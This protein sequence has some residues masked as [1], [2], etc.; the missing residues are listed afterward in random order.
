MNTDINLPKTWQEMAARINYSWLWVNTR[1][2]DIRLMCLEAEKF[3]IP[4]VVVNPCNVALASSLVR[5]TDVKVAA[6][7][8]Y[9]VGAY[10]ASA[11]AH[12][13]DDAVVDG[14]DEIYMVMA[15]GAYLSDWKNDFLLPELEALKTHAAGRRTTFI[16]EACVLSDEQKKEV[17]DLAIAAKI[18]FLAAGAGF[19]PSKLPDPTNAELETLVKAANGKIG[20][21]Y[22]G[23]IAD[24][25][26]ALELLSLGVARL[27]TP[28]ARTVLAGFADFSGIA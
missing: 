16:T 18:D 26:R 1:E 6:A 17:V 19:T 7:V 25:K 14:A 15:V 13:I 8:S 10:P 9:P 24:Q 5:G 20:I 12:E 11:K 22:M 28:S 3:H 2:K 4:T 27:C 23:E 21:T